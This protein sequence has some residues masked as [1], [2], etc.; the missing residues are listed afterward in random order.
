MTKK[1]RGTS[2]RELLSREVVVRSA[3]FR[4]STSL[5]KQRGAPTRIE[6]GPW[7]E[8]SGDLNEHLRE[9]TAVEF[10][11]HRSDR[12]RD[13]ESEPRSVGAIIALRPRVQVVVSVPGEEFDR[14]WS[15]ALADQL[16]HVHF[17]FEAP[18]RNSALVINA[19]FSNGSELG[20]D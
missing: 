20:E 7:L 3:V 17:V 10:N 6:S 8:L 19:S 15:M 9:V 1:Q 11:V 2:A 16:K 12:E 14:I 18:N 13:H 5:D 4:V